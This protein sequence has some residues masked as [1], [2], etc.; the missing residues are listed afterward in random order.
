MLRKDT[1]LPDDVMD[2][3]NSYPAF[4]VYDGIISNAFWIHSNFSDIEDKAERD[5]LHPMY[6][7]CRCIWGNYDYRNATIA[8]AREFLQWI[9]PMWC[10]LKKIK[11]T[12]FFEKEL[13]TFDDDD[14]LDI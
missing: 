4:H 2:Y 7:F 14:M 12:G 9:E 5:C 11:T 8:D 3:I 1:K 10:K 6:K 13:E